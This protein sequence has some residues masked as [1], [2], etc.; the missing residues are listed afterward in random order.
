MI[1][2]RPLLINADSMSESN[3]GDHEYDR[4]VHLIEGLIFITETIDKKDI[5]FIMKSLRRGQH[6]LK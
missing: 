4:L 1:N 6:S 5:M 2:C 3:S